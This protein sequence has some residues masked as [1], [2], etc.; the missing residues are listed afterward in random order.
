[1]PTLS[2]C[3]SKFNKFSF[4]EFCMPHMRDDG[5]DGMCIFLQIREF[6]QSAKVKSAGS[7]LSSAL[8]L[9]CIC[10]CAPYWRCWK[11]L[12]TLL[13][14]FLKLLLAIAFESCFCCLFA[15]QFY[16][17][18]S[19]FTQKHSIN[20]SVSFSP[21]VGR[22]LRFIHMYMNYDWIPAVNRGMSRHA[23]WFMMNLWRHFVN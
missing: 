21:F 18:R 8:W 10:A 17:N 2:A 11:H 16:C 1:M 7:A 15:F 19:F 3:L 14:L 13:T 22:A 5:I 6:L 20:F 12:S 23:R 4:N 9:L